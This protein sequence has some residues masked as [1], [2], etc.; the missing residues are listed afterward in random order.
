[1]LVY[2]VPGAGKTRLAGSY[3]RVL[4]LR[5]PT[6]NTNAIVENSE[7]VEEIVLRD[8]SDV[9]EAQQYAFAEGY[10]EFDWI[11]LDSISLFQDFG[12]D[13]VLDYAIN[14]KPARAIEK[15]GLKI[16]EY[17]PDKGEYGVNMTRLAKFCRDFVG[18][19]D[20]GKFN[21]GITAHPFET[22]DPI[23]EADIWMPWVQGNM[24]SDK[25]CGYMNIVAYLKKI[26]KEGKTQRSLLTQSPGFYGKDEFHIFPEL[27]GGKRGL[28]DPDMEKITKLIAGSRQAKQTKHRRRPKR[29][30]KVRRRK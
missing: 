21:F 16:P 15:G 28:I 18:K 2:S 14:R 19:A 13:D 27:K 22:F 3:G 4:I 30:K 9:Y 24:M 8:W 1:M 29:S 20:E 17:G 12:L 11:W 7:N 6:D 25:I 26:E 10:K 5:P 23:A